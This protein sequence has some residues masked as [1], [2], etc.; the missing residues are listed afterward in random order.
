MSRPTPRRPSSSR[1]AT[2]R[3]RKLAKGRPSAEPET[4]SDE[5]VADEAEPAEPEAEE[6]AVD[7]AEHHDETEP[8]PWPVEE[9]AG[10]ESSSLLNSPRVTRMLLAMAAVI[11]LLLMVE[12]AWGVVNLVTDDDEPERERTAEGTIAVPEHSPVQPTELVVQ[13]GVEAAAKAAQ[14]IVSRTFENYDAEVE[15]ASELLTGSF[16]TE[17][18]Q[19]TDDVRAEFIAAK[20]T[21]QARVVGQGVVRANDTELQA[22]LFIDQ[23]VI[24]STGKE[25]KTTRTPYRALLTMVNTD[26]GWLVEDMQT[27]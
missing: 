26:D 6:V 17:Y 18:R 16:A 13:A 4:P 2:P 20:T 12:A 21:V 8:E 19:T 9:P 1:A 14:K 10:G 5:S 24:T 3:P 23:Y 22:L 27:E 11:A 7:E 25:P 15:A